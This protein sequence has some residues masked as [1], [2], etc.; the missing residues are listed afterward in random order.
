M[1]KDRPCGNIC[2]SLP[3]LAGLRAWSCRQ[4]VAYTINPGTTAG[5]VRE[6]V[7]KLFGKAPDLVRRL[8]ALDPVLVHAHFGPDGL[9]ALPLSRQLGLPLIVTFHGS[10]ATALNPRRGEATF[11]HRRYLAHRDTLQ[12]GASLFLA[13][14]DFIR[15]KLLEQNV[16][17]R[18]S[19][20]FITSE[21]IPDSF[22]PRASKPN[23][24]SSSLDG[25]RRE[26][27]PAI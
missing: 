16:R 8:H 6:V 18:K 12:R 25:S 11:G 5:K 19:S 23:R 20:S 13:V 21:W 14:S 1:L 17:A 15:G 3:G 4:A 10:D 26:K 2:P 7:F 24:S 9:R 27:A 22:R